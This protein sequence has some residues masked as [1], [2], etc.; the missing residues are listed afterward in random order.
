VENDGKEE[1]QFPADIRKTKQ[2]EEVYRI[3]ASAAGPVSAAEIYCQLLQEEKGNFAI[4]TIYRALA[5]FEE[6]GYVV[7]TSLTGCEMSY[8]EWRR[9]RHRHYAVCLKCHKR[10]PLKGCPFE[11]AHMDACEDFMVTGHKLELYGYCK[12][13]GSGEKAAL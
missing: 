1:L 12:G 2:R 13:C 3:L 11:A 8:Y 10:I 7:K 5:V 4:S 9:E 6:K